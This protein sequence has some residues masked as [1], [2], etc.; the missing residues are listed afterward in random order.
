MKSMPRKLCGNRVCGCVLCPDCPRITV[1]ELIA[2][3]VV[4]FIRCTIMLEIILCCSSSA[5]S[6]RN[7]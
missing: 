1:Q 5:L 4:Y 3:T 6:P 7:E 2:G